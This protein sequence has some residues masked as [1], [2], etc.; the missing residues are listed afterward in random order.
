MEMMANYLQQPYAYVYA[1][2][3]NTGDG[4]TMA[5][6]VGANLWHMSNSAGYLWG[7]LPPDA[8]RCLTVT[9]NLGIM[10]G[11]NAARFM[12]ETTSNRHGRINIGG[13]WVSMPVP[14]PTWYIMDDA[15]VSAN[16]IIRSFSEGNADEIANGWIIKA[17]TI[18]ELAA[19]CELDAVTLKTTVDQWNASCES[20]SD[21]LY[22][23][24]ADKMVPVSTGPF[25][26]MK[27]GPTMY[28][29]QGGPERNENAEI[30]DLNGNP[31]PHLYSCGELGA[32]WPDM[33]NGGGNLAEASIYGRIAGTN[34][35]AQK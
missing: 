16:K 29:T 11:T 24:P 7:F 26:A 28:N 32:M 23:R 19:A 20:G 21:G 14:L 35:A 27:L 12:D 17:D 34:A 25:Y 8:E 9:P 2:P 33:Y 10:V 18:E 6:E 31:I 30:L 4:I 5:R 1:A 13:R 22:G 15:Q 3:Y